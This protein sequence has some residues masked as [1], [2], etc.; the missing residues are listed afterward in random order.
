MEYLYS[1]IAGPEELWLGHCSKPCPE[2]IVR[3]RQTR[4]RGLLKPTA[5]CSARQLPIKQPWRS[6]IWPRIPPH[7]IRASQSKLS[8]SSQA[9]PNIRVW[10]QQ[11]GETGSLAK[12]ILREATLAETQTNSWRTTYL[13][14]KSQE[15]SRSRSRRPA[16]VAP[17][18]HRRR[19]P[20]PKPRRWKNMLSRSE[21]RLK[22]S[23]LLGRLRNR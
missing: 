5:S 6:S 12:R 13:W 14:E 3:Q 4:W 21:K 19:K 20:K 23:N 18:Q 8:M 11:P 17:N 1:R 9:W 15:S 2:L 7:K 16:S 22:R 10:R